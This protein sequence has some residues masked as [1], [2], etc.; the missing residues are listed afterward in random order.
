MMLHKENE[1]FWIVEKSDGAI[2][3]F[4]NGTQTQNT[5]EGPF[6]SYDDAM[7][8]KQCYRR[9]GCT[10]YAIVESDERPKNSSNEYEFV[11]AY[12]EFDDV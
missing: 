1:M 3:G 10:W 8:A 2:M 4:V 12:H 9:Y 5:M 7:K 11:D 6:K